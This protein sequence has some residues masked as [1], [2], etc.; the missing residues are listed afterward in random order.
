MKQTGTPMKPGTTPRERALFNVEK[1]TPHLERLRESGKDIAVP[2]HDEA[3]QAIEGCL[4]GR[5]AEWLKSKPKDKNG[6]LAQVLWTL[7]KFHGGGGSLWGWPH[8]EDKEI[9]NKMDTLALVLR[10][11]KSSAA[12]AWKRALRGT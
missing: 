2:S 12:S 7:M 10:G 11:G 5:T 9:V 8:F 4:N 1:I 3:L 6:T